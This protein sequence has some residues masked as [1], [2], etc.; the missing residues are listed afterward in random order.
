M[1][2]NNWMRKRKLKR[3][4]GGGDRG[5]KV[6]YRGR[7]GGKREGKK[8]LEQRKKERINRPS[9]RGGRYKH[10]GRFWQSRLK[11]EEVGLRKRRGESEKRRNKKHSGKATT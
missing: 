7:G 11:R 6:N 1:G 2:G 4:K 8:E 10:G 9:I 3:R 5:K